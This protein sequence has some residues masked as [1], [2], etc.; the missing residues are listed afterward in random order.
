MIS[1]IRLAYHHTRTTLFILL[2][3]LITGVVS[4]IN[5]P[6]ES[7]PDISIPILYV[8]LSHEGISPE[9]AETLLLKP[10][11]REI[12]TIEGIKELKS[13]GYEGGGNLIIEFNAGYNIKKALRDVREKVDIAKAN[14]P[15]DTHE[16]TVKEINFSQFPILVVTLAGDLPERT[17]FKLA[18][19]LKDKIES[20]PSILEAKIYGDRDELG[21]I[22]INPLL[23]ESY[24]LVA[25]DM[26]GFFN[27]SH[28]LVA[29]GSLDTGQGR[30][31]LKVPGLFETTE[32]ILQMPVKVKGDSVIK[33]KDIATGGRTFKDRTTYAR[34]NGKP[35]V[36]IEV[37]KRAGE[38]IIETVEKVI[39]IVGEEQTRWPKQLQ[40]SFSQDQSHRVKDMIS[41]LQNNVA[42]A[43]FLVMV[44]IV[45][46][47]GL[48][49]GALVGLAIPGSFLIG[50]LAL[51]FMGLTVNIVVLFGLIFAV[52]MLV[53]DAIIVVEYANRRMDEG[54]PAKVAYL[55]AAERMA[56]PVVASTFTRLAAFSPLLFWPGI[57]GEF[58]KFMPIT[59][60]A[61]LSASLIM[62]LFFIPC[63]GQYL[64]QTQIQG[65]ESKPSR[66]T[67][68][69][70]YV[71][72][73]ALDKPWR[74]AA[75]TG[76]SL[77]TIIVL[78]FFLGKGVEFFP[79]IE[80]DNAVVYVHAMGN[81]S[82]EEQDHFVK[83]VEQQI[84]KMPYFKTV[85]TTSGK[86]MEFRA[87]RNGGKPDAE[88][89]IGTINLELKNWQERPKVNAILEEI[90]N[91]TKNL[92]GIFVEAQKEKAGPS[93]GKPIQV[94]LR[95]LDP[96]LLKPWLQKIK[97]YLEKDKDYINIE[98]DLP[99][100]GIEWQLNVNRA[101]ASKYRTDISVIGET[102][103]MVTSGI[104]LGSFRPND[105]EDEV[106]IVV[107]YPYENRSL[108]ELDRL[109]I[110]S[111]EGNIPVSH[112]VKRIAKP[113]VG[114][115]H[116]LDGRR[117]HNIKADV[118]PGIMAD[119]KMKELNK[120]LAAQ[121]VPL[122]VDIQF[123]G[124]DE[125]KKKSAAF[126]QKAFLASLCLMLV[127][128]VTQYNS[129]Y[130]SFVTLSAV[131][132]STI[133]VLIGMLV[134][135]QAF[136]IVMN[137]LGVVAL[138]GII[139]NNNIILIDTFKHIRGQ[140]KTVKEALIE[141]GKQRLRPVFLTALT[142][143]LGLLPLVFSLNIDILQRHITHGSPSTQWWVQLS[144]AIAFGLSF[145]T[146]L[147][148]IV[149][150]CALILW[151]K[152]VKKAL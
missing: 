79:D 145:A 10:M 78:T 111:Q 73:K 67:E 132:F 53:D 115:I 71:L 82:V 5:I 123:K 77:I 76:A 69:Y 106:D 56:W 9:D 38:N 12:R 6:K 22:V 2:F 125:S 107:R 139:V 138:G 65:E 7:D 143:V 16:P 45:S 102:I 47:L 83:E 74:V 14:L 104:R 116:R 29:A 30:F 50:I 131:I 134:M 95:S 44:V 37:S 109:K 141:T 49:S 42:T 32:D 52:G 55:E 34:L 117:T 31:S 144:T 40:I 110:V 148:L 11:E 105:A 120:W 24:N 129:F 63:L 57:T 133:G 58:M 3:I 72:D 75:A 114:T 98:T 113:Q 146:I 140:F 36:V 151:E 60:I 59:L 96:V 18:R 149:T 28:K 20:I 4:Y 118:K 39:A 61:T 103:K 124:D 85:Y 135:N 68:L 127:I 70:L 43:V 99:L 51:S 136:S 91:K 17:L 8:T 27:R 89:I 150:P 21:E 126:L 122:D 90:R 142:A 25:N 130:E 80:P 152:K 101:E 41:D 13:K 97:A 108:S 100:P 112:F 87:S 86:T 1:L 35:A 93:T 92:A 84:L 26:V 54:L 66:M 33:L 15:K 128:L 23:V 147:T 137:G 81:L 62:A 94:Q 64:G 19:H 48:R 119:A 121:K 88:D 46:A